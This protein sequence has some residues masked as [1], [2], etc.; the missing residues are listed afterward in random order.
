M[1]WRIYLSLGK[2]PIMVWAKNARNVIEKEG[3]LET[4][5]QVRATIIA[6]YIGG[7]ETGWVP[8][9]LFASP[10]QILR[11]VPKKFLI[12]HIVEHG[13]LLIERR[14][15]DSELPDVEILEALAH[16]YG[17]FC[18]MTVSLFNRLGLKAPPSVAHGRP[19]TWGDAH[20]MD[21]AI[22]LSMR[23][24]SVRGYR[25]I[26][27]IRQMSV[28]EQQKIARRYN[29]NDSGKRFLEAK[30][31]QD[32]AAA[33]FQHAR[34][35]MLRDGYHMSLALFL[36]GNAV[37]SLIDTTHPDRASR[38]I[39]MRDLAKLTKIAGANGV[40]L[41]GEV[42]TASKDDI[43]KSGFAVDA[44]NREEGLM[45]NAANSKGETISFYAKVKRRRFSNK[46]KSLSETEDDRG[47]VPFLL[48]PFMKEWGCLTQE[49]IEKGFEAM[50]QIGIDAP[51]IVADPPPAQT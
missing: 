10:A 8:Q 33:Y 37:A 28:H 14:W 1:V 34:V 42:W 22:Y 29:I 39:I 6:S 36:R 12:P 24:G 38:Y 35:A 7:P 23:D 40:I 47:D 3:D 15:V 44:P 19:S 46:V 5:S 13:T 51:A 45:L 9:M 21:R 30:T 11:A 4:H 27:S 25:Y 48:Y 18:D 31:F 17:N 43:P 32:V 50:D 16:V 2:D 20:A 41:I 26:R 49:D